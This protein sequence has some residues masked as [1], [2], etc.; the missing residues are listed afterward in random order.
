MKLKI[1]Q[2]TN[3]AELIMDGQVIHSP[4][5]ALN[6]LGEC[7]MLECDKIIIRKE[8]LNTDFF[9]LKSQMAGEILQKFSN[10]RVKLAIIGDFS[11][12]PSR[13]LQSFIRESNRMGN[14]FFL[15]D[16][17]DAIRKLSNNT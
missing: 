14:V 10:Y 5:D 2:G 8:H 15:N 3:I 12:F 16:S 13:S 7:G 4:S 17:E 1:H 6:L 11:E 9:N